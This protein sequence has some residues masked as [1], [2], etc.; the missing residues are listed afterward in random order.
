[1]NIASSD[2]TT[3]LVYPL[4][5]S[6][7]V[8]TAFQRIVVDG[9]VVRLD[10]VNHSLDEAHLV[11]EGD[12]LTAGQ[13][14]LKIIKAGQKVLNIDHNGVLHC[15]ADL[16]A[17][18]I[19]GIISEIGTLQTSDLSQN[20]TIQANALMLA[21]ATPINTENTLVLRD[22][23]GTTYF[24]DITAHEIALQSSC[25][26]YGDAALT[27][28]PQDDSSPPLNL[29][30]FTYRFG[31]NTEE[32]GD[33]SGTGAGIEMKE[34]DGNAIMIQVNQTTPHIELKVKKLN[35]TI[36]FILIQDDE[37]HDLVKIDQHGFSE[38]FYIYQKTIV[39]PGQPY[40]SP[41]LLHGAQV[42]RFELGTK[43]S[44]QIPEIVIRLYTPELINADTH[45]TIQNLEVC[46]DDRAVAPGLLDIPSRMYIKRWGQYRNTVQ[47]LYI[48]LA[49]D[50]VGGATELEIS[51]QF[52]ITFNNNILL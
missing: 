50:Y 47:E 30:G 28:T 14:Y 40:D 44:N 19:T 43:W 24:H 13:D 9:G 5:E 10:S 6:E 21:A 22:N 37:K 7:I 38:K 36:P 51:S 15:H 27:Y 25:D 20:T 31:R 29:T 2:G 17:P 8:G 46:L 3:T 52:R 16:T 45:R 18:V 26:L 49:V 1:M 23:S 11:L 33:F 41:T 34:P 32:I 42:H 39:T 4:L 48:I 12:D 35:A